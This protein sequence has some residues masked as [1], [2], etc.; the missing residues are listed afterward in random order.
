MTDESYVLLRIR[1]KPGQ[2]TGPIEELIQLLTALELR[3][4][5]VEA[6]DVTELVGAEQTKYRWL[7]ERLPSTVVK[8]IES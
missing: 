6:A 1:P 4:I 8:G 7:R 2:E 5:T 3:T